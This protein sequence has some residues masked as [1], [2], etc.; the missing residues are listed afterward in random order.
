MSSVLDFVFANAVRATVS[1][2]KGTDVLARMFMEDSLYEGGEQAALQ[3]PTFISNHDIGRFAGFVRADRPKASDAEVLKRV[4]L[5]HAMLLTLRGAPVV[6]YGGC[7][8]RSR[9]RCVRS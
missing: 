5:A 1:G 7:R 4:A 2:N 9:R 8:A 6:Y 3:L